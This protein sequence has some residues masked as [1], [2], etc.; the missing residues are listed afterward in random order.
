MHV[1][2]DLDSVS[3]TIIT[4]SQNILDKA[5]LFIKANSKTDKDSEIDDILSN[6]KLLGIKRKSVRL[7]IKHSELN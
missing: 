6:P 1:T 7:Y 5:E 3:I 4:L 2:S